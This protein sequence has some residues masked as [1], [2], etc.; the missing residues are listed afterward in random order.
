MCVCGV[1]GKTDYTATLKVFRVRVLSVAKR[2]GDPRRTV[3]L[4]KLN[5]VCVRQTHPTEP[6]FKQAMEVPHESR[7]P[8][9]TPGTVT[10]RWQS[11]RR[12]DT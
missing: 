10:T 11:E 7:S 2:N 6:P 5:D 8:H 12:I 9:V 3:D 1:C 4:E